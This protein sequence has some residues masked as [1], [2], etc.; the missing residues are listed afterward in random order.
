M[1]LYIF[2]HIIDVYEGI[3]VAIL[4]E[5]DFVVVHDRYEHFHFLMSLR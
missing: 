4:S 2:R 1:N 5:I 3:D